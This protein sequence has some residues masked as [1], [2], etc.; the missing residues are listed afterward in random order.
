MAYGRRMESMISIRNHIDD[1]IWGQIWDRV[2]SYPIYHAAR[3]PIWVQVEDR[4]T[5]RLTR[6]IRDPLQIRLSHRIHGEINQ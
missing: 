1:Q 5:D 3:E 4:L 2:K 6:S